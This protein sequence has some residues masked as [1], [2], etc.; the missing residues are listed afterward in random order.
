MGQSNE[1]EKSIQIKDLTEQH[2]KKK[3]KLNFSTISTFTSVEKQVWRLK[4]SMEFIS[5]FKSQL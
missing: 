3:I 5:S 4:N 1:K 2:V